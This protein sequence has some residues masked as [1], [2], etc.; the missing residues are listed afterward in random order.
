MERYQITLHS[1]MGPR[2]GTL[3]LVNDREAVLELLGFRSTV[4][5][6]PMDGDRLGLTGD[7]D[8]IMGKISFETELTIRDGAFDSLAR[9]GKGNMRLTG[10]HI[11]NME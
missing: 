5:I 6:R 3:E 10:Q 9:T 11:E 2:R 8:S 1:P 4:A 7:L